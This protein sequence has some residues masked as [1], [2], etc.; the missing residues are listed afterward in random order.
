MLP[1]DPDGTCQKAPELGLLT[2]SKVGLNSQNLCGLRWPMR[3][4]L[5]LPAICV[6]TGFWPRLSTEVPVI[7]VNSLVDEQPRSPY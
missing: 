1:N 5:Q 2:V 3:V 4:S 7:T 6:P